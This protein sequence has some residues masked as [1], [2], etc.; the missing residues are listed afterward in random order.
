ML[1]N[2]VLEI[3]SHKELAQSYVVDGAVSSTA[4]K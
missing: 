2:G 1:W 4:S 3:I